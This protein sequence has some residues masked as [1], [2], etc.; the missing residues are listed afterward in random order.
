[1]ERI[2]AV[3]KL[4]KMLGKGFGYRINTK[5]PDQDE[6]EAAKAALPEANAETKRLKEAK[7]ARLEAVLAADAEY[8]TLKAAHK[9]AEDRA[10]KLFGI[11]RHYKLTVG[12]SNG[13]FFHILAEAD[14]WEDV[15]AKLQQSK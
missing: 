6:R 5:A 9:V 1:M 2:V 12:K 4:S 13:M 15:I 11:S 3:K 8:Q 14:S 7:R 10:E